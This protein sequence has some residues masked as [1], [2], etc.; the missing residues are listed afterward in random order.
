MLFPFSSKGQPGYGWKK[1]PTRSIEKWDDLCYEFINKFFLPLKDQNLR[2]EISSD[3]SKNLMR[4]FVRLGSLHDLLRG[5]PHHGFSELHNSI[6]SIMPK[7]IDQDSFETL[8]LVVTFLDQSAR[9]CFKNLREQSLRTRCL[10]LITE[11]PKT[12]F[13]KPP[14]VQIQS[15]NPNPE[16]NVSPVD[17]PIPK[18]SIP[19][20]SRRNDERR[21][22]KANEQIEKFY[23]IFKDMNFEISFLDALTLMA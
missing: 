8:M 19:F 7:L 3:F 15:R 9:E 13:Q 21:K 5:C 2:N 11:A 18:A 10:L 14:V 16:P 17:T 1:K 12:S 6:H 4:R 20:P 23:E 22:E